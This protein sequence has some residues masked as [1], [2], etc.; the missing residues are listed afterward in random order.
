MRVTWSDS[1]EAEGTGESPHQER[2]VTRETK[3]FSDRLSMFID[4]VGWSK[5]SDLIELP[6][7][8]LRPRGLDQA[9]LIFLSPRAIYHALFF[10]VSMLSIWASTLHFACSLP[11]EYT[12]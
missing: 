6:A 4:G 12:R 2:L 1:G 3:I 11:Q 7:L 8:K 5:I 9:A 10:I